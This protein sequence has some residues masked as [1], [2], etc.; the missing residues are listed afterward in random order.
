MIKQELV[1]KSPVRFFEK[2]TNG[3]L[4][5]GEV[6]VLASKKGLGKTSVL[7]QFGLDMLLQD[8][9]VIHVSFNQKQ[10][11]VM[12][13]YED[14]YAEVSKRKNL[15]EADALKTELVKKRIILNFNQ[16]VKAAQIIKSLKALAE[17]GIKVNA[18]I[19]DGLKLSTVAA[20]IVADLKAYAKEAG[21]VI[22]LS[23]STTDE[24]TVVP[25][26]IVDIADMVIYLDHKVDTT[27]MNISKNREN[28]ATGI[29]LK[30]DTKTLLMVEK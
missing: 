28:A 22:W 6:G 16:E 23:V 29:Q 5:A 15:S 3:G 1:D 12:S 26:D 13:W 4:K 30:L 21:I 11:F 2:S 24:V 8:K 7:V 18:L 27:V 10:D 17:G 19:I 20:E 14:I 25:Q 9:Q